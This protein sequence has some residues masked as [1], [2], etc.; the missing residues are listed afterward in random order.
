MESP[1]SNA[2]PGHLKRLGKHILSQVMPN[3][4]AF[5][6]M[7]SVLREQLKIWLVILLQNTARNGFP[8][9]DGEQR[10]YAVGKSILYITSVKT[11]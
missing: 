3:V 5:V 8:R 1:T 9:D 4:Y 10:N 11:G 7:E 2:P 6:N